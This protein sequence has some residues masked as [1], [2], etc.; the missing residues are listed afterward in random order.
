LLPDVSL[1][2]FTSE[3]LSTAQTQECYEVF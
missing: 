1:R 2:S 3:N